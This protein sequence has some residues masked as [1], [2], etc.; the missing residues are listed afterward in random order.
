MIAMAALWLFVPGA[1]TNSW[2]NASCCGYQHTMERRKADHVTEH[3]K[4]YCDFLIGDPH[5][6]DALQWKSVPDGERLLVLGRS[7]TLEGYDHGDSWYKVRTRDGRTGYV[8]YSG[9]KCDGA[10]DSCKDKIAE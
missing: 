5:K 6:I 1:P 3:L 10:S 4:K 7:E 2:G 9:V 8:D